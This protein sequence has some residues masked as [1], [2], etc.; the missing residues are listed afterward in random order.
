MCRILVKVYIIVRVCLLAILQSLISL[1]L[2]LKLCLYKHMYNVHVYVMCGSDH[3]Y[4]TWM[5]GMLLLLNSFE[6]L[7][8]SLAMSCGYFGNSLVE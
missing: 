7:Y 5:C 1:R 2:K 4:V 6:S 8:S 3:V